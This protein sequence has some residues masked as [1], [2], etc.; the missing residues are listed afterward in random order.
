MKFSIVI[1]V[2]NVEDYIDKCLNSIRK[3]TYDNFEAIIVNDGSPDNSEVIIKK[4]LKDKRFRYYKKENGGLSDARNYGVKYTTGD[5]LLFI[6]SDDYIDKSLLEKINEI[7]ESKQVDVVRFNLN[8]VD[9]EGN[10][11]RSAGDLY[12]TDDTKES[13]LQSIIASGFVEAAC[14]YAYNLT[15]WRK[16]NFQYSKGKIH[17]DYGLTPLVLSKARNIKVLNYHGYNYVQRENSIM[18]QNNYEK[19]I[20]KVDDFKFH[21]LNLIDKIS[22]DSLSNKLI[23]SFM[24]EA[25]IYKGRELNDDDRYKFVKFIKE[26]SVIGNIYC[27][28]LRKLLKKIYLYFFLKKYLSKLNKKFVEEKH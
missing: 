10:L 26:N 2:Y 13:I 28:N 9:D 14:F 6:D 12:E 7:L 17:E 21:Y 4:Y 22:S 27:Y 18:S 20:I 15:F 11:I 3:Q 24:A 16:N 8:L 5:Y 23:R 19:T 25:L 1:P